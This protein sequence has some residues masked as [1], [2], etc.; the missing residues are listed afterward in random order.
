MCKMYSKSIDYFNDI[1]LSWIWKI[2]FLDKTHLYWFSDYLHVLF[3]LTVYNTVYIL[4]QLGNSWVT[5][6][7]NKK[8]FTLSVG[9]WKRSISGSQTQEHNQTKWS[10]PLHVHTAKNLE[11][12]LSCWSLAVAIVNYLHRS[13]FMN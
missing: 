11:K 12:E 5:I 10:V 4:D 3:L 2:F 8:G 6:W 1:T 7:T 9:W 13:F